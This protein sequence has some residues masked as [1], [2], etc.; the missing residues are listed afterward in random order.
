[1]DNYIVDLLDVAVVAIDANFKVT[2]FNKKAEK[3]FNIHA[4]D[5]INQSVEKLLNYPPENVRYLQRTLE[6][7]KDLTIDETEH[8]FGSYEQSLKIDTK[9]IKDNGQ[10]I[11]GAMIVFTDIINDVTKRKLNQNNLNNESD[12]ID[13]SE[14][15]FK[16]AN[17]LKRDLLQQQKYNLKIE[18]ENKLKEVLLE[19]LNIG[20]V[21]EE[22]GKI[23]VLNRFFVRL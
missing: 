23:T 1:M 14:H 3:I 21:L 8:N 9:L 4:D 12:I 10:K 22:D 11:I 18:Q 19:N 15:A 5:A 7:Q 13:N 2:T 16:D 17:D 20:L 6:E